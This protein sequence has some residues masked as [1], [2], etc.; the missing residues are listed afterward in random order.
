M[1][2]ERLRDLKY[3]ALALAVAFGISACSLEGDDGEDGVA[4]AVGEQG[5]VGEQGEQG[6]QGD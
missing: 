2:I 4:G 1:K 6:E 5:P 3:S